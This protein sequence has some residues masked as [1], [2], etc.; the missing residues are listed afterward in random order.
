MYM[1]NHVKKKE[2]ALYQSLVNNIIK[3]RFAVYSNVVGTPA[4]VVSSI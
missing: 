3:M 1:Y 2:S 4:V